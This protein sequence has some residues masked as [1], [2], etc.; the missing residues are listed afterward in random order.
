MSEKFGFPFKRKGITTAGVT[1]RLPQQGGK[2]EPFDITL[3]I[4]KPKEGEK[5]P[6]PND[7]NSFITTGKLTF[8]FGRKGSVELFAENIS[9]VDETSFDRGDAL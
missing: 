6:D 2:D 4:T 7:E 8:R 1:I 5:T 9:Q 3:Y